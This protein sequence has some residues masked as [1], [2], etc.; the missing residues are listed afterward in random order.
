MKY[1]N[2]SD[3]E[4]ALEAQRRETAK[5]SSRQARAGAI[6]AELARANRARDEETAEVLGM[7]YVEYRAT[8]QTGGVSW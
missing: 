8:L 6:G 5:A 1:A 7:S 3:A 4:T 2:R